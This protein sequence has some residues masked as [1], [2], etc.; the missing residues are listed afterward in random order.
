MK[1]SFV[2]LNGALNSWRSTIPPNPPYAPYIPTV[3]KKEILNK[4][5]NNS[6]PDSGN[7][8]SLWLDLVSAVNITSST[9]TMAHLGQDLMGPTILWWV[10][11]I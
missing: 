10:P 2:V 6:D 8:E 1:F 3:D 7:L 4:Y 5:R 11:L 9:Y